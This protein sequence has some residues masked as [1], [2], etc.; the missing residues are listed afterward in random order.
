MAIQDTLGKTV[1]NIT[2][3]VDAFNDI[4]MDKS[5]SSFQKCLGDGFPYD[6]LQV[7]Q[8]YAKNLSTVLNSSLDE[9]ICG[10]SVID[11]AKELIPTPD[12]NPDIAK[13]TDKYAPLDLFNSDAEKE[14]YLNNGLKHNHTITSNNSWIGKRIG[15]FK[16]NTDYKVIETNVPGAKSVTFTRNLDDGEVCSYTI[17]IEQLHR[18]PNDGLTP[19]TDAEDVLPPVNGIFPINGDYT[20]SNTKIGSAHFTGANID[21]DY[22]IERESE[23]GD[24]Y[25]T[26]TSVNYNNEWCDVSEKLTSQQKAD[27]DAV[28]VNNMQKQKQQ[29]MNTLKSE[30]MTSSLLNDT[31]NDT[32]NTLKDSAPALGLIDTV[33][34][35]NAVK[36]SIANSAIS[37]I[38][39]DGL[40]IDTSFVKTLA[41]EITN[42]TVNSLL[43][44][45]GIPG[46]ISKNCSMQFLEGA[47]KALE[48]VGIGKKIDIGLYDFGGEIISLDVSSLLANNVMKTMNSIFSSKLLSTEC[49]QALNNQFDFISNDIITAQDALRTITGLK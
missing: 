9:L 14:A 1:T 11:K 27:I 25:I 7:A 40:S 41:N 6:I 46:D 49:L 31:L 21:T 24:T 20:S 16:G 10:M 43:E 26:L 34:V 33:E 32:I 39:G 42:S 19:T 29:A 37:M 2:N 17:S 18:G 4:A 3:K 36:S 5:L 15:P 30:F 28:S 12:T 8:N 35:A 38:S 45:N 44:K 47:M 22:I 23:S 48:M 13:L